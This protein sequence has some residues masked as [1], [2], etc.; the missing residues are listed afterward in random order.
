MLTS[1]LS[2]SNKNSEIIEKQFKKALEEGVQNDN[3]LLHMQKEFS[4][5]KY[6]SNLNST[7][8]S[9]RNSE[10]EQSNLLMSRNFS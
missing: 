3:R 8:L 9:Q 5:K 7:S 4:N 10:L 1:E 6:Q 2:A